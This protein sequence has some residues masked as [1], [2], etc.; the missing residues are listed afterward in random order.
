MPIPLLKWTQLQVGMPNGAVFTDLFVL[1]QQLFAMGGFSTD[2]SVSF[3]D[4]YVFDILPDGTL[5]K[6]RYIGII[7]KWAQHL[8]TSGVPNVDNTLQLGFISA[9]GS[10]IT[11]RSTQKDVLEFI[12]NPIPGLITANMT[13]SVRNGHILIYD[14]SAASP[15]IWI[16]KYDG[17]GNITELLLQKE[18]LP[19]AN[20]NQ[21]IFY[22]NIIIYPCTN[23]FANRQPYFANVS[24]DGLIGRTTGF[25]SPD[26]SEV[27]MDYSTVVLVGNNIFC[28][29]AFNA[30]T[31]QSEGYDAILHLNDDG[32]PGIWTTIPTQTSM[33]GGFASD[34]KRYLWFNGASSDFVHFDSSFWVLRAN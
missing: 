30:T 5:S 16:G 3:F 25:L 24:G 13:S 33:L 28:L 19:F 18:A 15:D 12:N 6:G 14:N 17:R 4:I 23:D 26:G 1:G 20:S 29:N 34:G 10:I 11:I 22:K 7:P 21:G 9:V 8:T 31:S 27:S 32:S 2:F